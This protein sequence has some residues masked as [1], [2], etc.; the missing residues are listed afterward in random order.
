MGAAAFA[1]HQQHVEVMFMGLGQAG[2]ALLLVPEYAEHFRF[3]RNANVFDADNRQSVLR[4]HAQKGG[5]KRKYE[6]SCVK[7]PFVA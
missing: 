7:P 5:T 6:N 2:L 4:V 3:Q 1:D